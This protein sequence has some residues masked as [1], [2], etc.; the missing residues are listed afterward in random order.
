MKRYYIEI[1]GN[2]KNT[3]DMKAPADMCAIMRARGY[4]AIPF[5][6]PRSRGKLEGLRTHLANWGKVYRRVKK[7]DLAVYQYPLL[8][9]HLCVRLL[10]GL[11]RIRGAKLVL[12]IHDIDSI[13]GLHAADN[14]WKETVFQH[15]DYLICHNERMQ[16]WLAERGVPGT[17]V[18][19][20]VF[21]YLADE[22]TDSAADG[23]AVI[24]AGNLSAKK[25]PYIGKLLEAE[26]ECRI[27]LY[28]P[29]FEPR[30]EYRNCEYFGSFPPEELKDHLQGGFGLVWD[31]DS[32]EECSGSTG[33]YLRWNNPHK[34]SLYLSA[35]I[36]VIIWKEAALAPWI[37]ENGL[38]IAI[39]SLR[40][41]DGAVRA[42]AP[43]RRAQ[44]R[45][46]VRREG[47][48]I[49]AG[50]YLNRALDRIEEA[51][52]NRRGSKP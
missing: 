7:G 13:R 52:R 18:P 9:S 34:V 35:G 17:I 28:G 2:E 8:L 32:L 16:A 46:N 42:L 15:A 20:G 27:H 33:E 49:R 23:D 51:E 48:K 37:E 12:L 25:S 40:E 39:G 31:G 41:L 36:P 3:A 30:E 50:A 11:G 1:R 29:N 10:C 44:I 4:E 21:D 6:R 26:R 38:G 14:A 24:I 22:R 19:L 5:R 47:A 45:E 43:A